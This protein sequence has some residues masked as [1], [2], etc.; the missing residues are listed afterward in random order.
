[1]KMHGLG[2]DAAIFGT[3]EDYLLRRIEGD[4]G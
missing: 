3:L 1:M 2:K 4:S